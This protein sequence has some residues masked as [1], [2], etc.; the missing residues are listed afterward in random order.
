MK[1][2][3]MRSSIIWILLARIELKLRS[4]FLTIF[5]DNWVIWISVWMY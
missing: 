4:H 5:V 2:N 3:A 1:P